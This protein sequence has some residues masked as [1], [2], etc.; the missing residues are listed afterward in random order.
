MHITYARNHWSVSTIFTEKC[1]QTIISSTKAN[2]SFSY[3]NLPN[4]YYRESW[5]THERDIFQNFA[6]L[7]YCRDNL[8]RIKALFAS[9]ARQSDTRPQICAI[10]S[11][12][13]THNLELL[14]CPTYH[15]RSVYSNLV[16]LWDTSH[17]F[18]SFLCRFHARVLEWQHYTRIE[19][20]AL[21]GRMDALLII[22]SKEHWYWQC[23]YCFSCIY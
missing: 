21:L 5:N 3:D 8:R 19:S 1:I 15:L 12:S 11:A 7:T 4:N 23:L 14:L 2:V 18:L 13:R 20:V 17:F 6:S 9:L 22:Y 10:L 16:E